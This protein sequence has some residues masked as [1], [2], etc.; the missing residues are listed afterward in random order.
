[1]VAVAHGVLADRSRNVV[2]SSRGGNKLGCFLGYR[3]VGES[4]SSCTS[5]RSSTTGLVGSGDVDP[6]VCCRGV[7]IEGDLHRGL[8]SLLDDHSLLDVSVH[9]RKNANVAVKG[10]CSIATCCLGPTEANVVDTFLHAWELVV[11]SSCEAGGNR[12]LKSCLECWARCNAAT[13]GGCGRRNPVERDSVPQDDASASCVG[14]LGNPSELGGG[15]VRSSRGDGQVGR[16][17]LSSC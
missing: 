7:E 5:I 8:G 1:M 2:C 10:H 14:F 4:A 13:R 17:E 9:N 11:D 12:K 16:A 15:R 3:S 6:V